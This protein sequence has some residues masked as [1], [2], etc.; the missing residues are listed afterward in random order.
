MGQCEEHFQRQNIKFYNMKS[1]YP[2]TILCLLLAVN[3]SNGFI[4]IEYPSSDVRDTRYD[5]TSIEFIGTVFLASLAAFLLIPHIQA[6]YGSDSISRT[7]GGIAPFILES[8]DVLENRYNGH[9]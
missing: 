7:I 4:E 3:I 9:T 5:I 1:N 2:V 8:I 6:Y